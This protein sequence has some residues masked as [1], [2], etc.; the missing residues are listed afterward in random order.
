MPYPNQSQQNDFNIRKVIEKLSS[1][2]EQPLSKVFSKEDL[3][4]PQH[5]AYLVASDLGDKMKIS[6]IRK[7]FDMVEQAALLARNDK[8]EKAQETIFMVVPNVAYATGRGL[9]EPQSF[10]D[11]MQMCINTKRIKTNEDI[12]TLFRFLQSIVAYKKK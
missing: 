12:E 10:N 6:Q 9:V 11:L 5:D 8:F 3:Y 2:P 7:I 1:R 4:L